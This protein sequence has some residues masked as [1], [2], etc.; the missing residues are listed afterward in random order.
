MFL[1]QKRGAL[2][3]I[4]DRVELLFLVKKQKS[5]LNFKV[6]DVSCLIYETGEA[7][8]SFESLLTNSATFMFPLM[9]RGASL[10]F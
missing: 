10:F 8:V 6:E 5:S 7:E 9:N 1:L 4:L 2:L 3:F